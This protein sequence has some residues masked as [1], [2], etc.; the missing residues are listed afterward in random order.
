MVR[1][2]LIFAISNFSPA[3]RPGFLS[4]TL[5]SFVMI[6]ISMIRIMMMVAAAVMFLSCASTPDKDEKNAEKSAVETS[7]ALS[8][9]D[10]T[11]PELRT[12]INY[13]SLSP[14]QEGSELTVTGLFSKGANGSTTLVTN[15]ESRSRVTFVLADP[16]GVLAATAPEDDS[17]ITITGILT[18]ASATWRKHLDVIAIR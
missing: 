17:I 11:Q 13:S 9:V 7:T 16:E 6:K 4:R 18:D 3:S 10:Q 14:E 15:P 12:Q 2:S 5:R 8:E 1:R